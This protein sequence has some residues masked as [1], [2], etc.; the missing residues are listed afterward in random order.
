MLEKHGID[1]NIKEFSNDEDA[2]KYLQKL[3][4]EAVNPL[5]NKL[6]SERDINKK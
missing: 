3:E 2:K 5:E 4:D 1:D 6:L